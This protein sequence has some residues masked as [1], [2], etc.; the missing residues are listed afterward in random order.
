MMNRLPADSK[1]PSESRSEKYDRYY[2]LNPKHDPPTPVALACEIIDSLDW[3]HGEVVLEPAR[4]TGPFFDNLPDYVV[5]D[6]C[7]ILEDR[8]FFDYFEQ[9]DTVITNPP[10]KSTMIDG[11]RTNMVV[12]YLEHAMELARKR[13]VFLI[14]AKS[15]MA[16]TPRRL[17]SW[18]DAGWHVTGIKVVSVKGWF[19]RYFVVRFEQDKPPVL[20]WDTNNY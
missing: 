7:E 15:F 17:Q 14:N 16:L 12:P 18:S 13:I 4:G 6:W 19:G 8:D 9:C 20:Q 5:K 1:K 2:T 10:F 3:D 11:K